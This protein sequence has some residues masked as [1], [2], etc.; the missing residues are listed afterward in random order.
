MELIGAA[1]QA[2][3]PSDFTLSGA[4]AKW[5]SLFICITITFQAILIFLQPVNWDEFRFLADIHQHRQG[6]LGPWL[7]TLHVHFFSWAVNVPGGEVSQ[8]IAG[9]CLI[10]LFECVTIAAIFVAARAFVAREE[11]LFAVLSYLAFSYV[12]RHG[13]SFRYD[14]I[15]TALLMSALALILW[16]RISLTRACI[17]AA[18]T[19]LAALVTVK[20]VFYLP[21]LA[22]AAIWRLAESQDS[23][24]DLVRI[25]IATGAGAATFAIV[26]IL[27][28]LTLAAPDAETAQRVVG[29][30]FLKTIAEAGL[31]PRLDAI[32]SSLVMDAL[33]WILIGLGLAKAIAALRSARRADPRLL[34]LLG[35]TL[36][37]ATLFFYRNAFPY[38]FA[39]ILAPATILA[40]F[41]LAGRDRLAVS[42]GAALVLLAGIHAATAPSPTLAVQ[43]AHVD[44]VHRMFPQPVPY[45]DR[46]SMIA[47]FPK[48]GFF[49]SSWGV[50]NYR[51]AGRPALREAVISTAPP[52]VIA[53]APALQ[54]AFAGDRSPLLPE[55]VQALRD[56]YIHHWGFLWVA[57]KHLQAVPEASV[58]Y[59]SIPGIYTIEGGGPVL[60]DHRTHRPG[61]TV[62]LSRGRHS[63]QSL[64]GEVDFTLRYGDNL[65]S[66]A[67]PPPSGPI[68]GDL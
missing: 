11:A 14:P 9:R 66:P 61:E 10:L 2:P 23:K 28:R 34:A 59:L 31:L 55:D 58:F 44:A 67:V 49:M 32:L 54:A 18:C 24:A 3:A 36:P 29:H 41:A 15:A 64:A 5:L 45:I 56:S 53:N 8:V 19:A 48:Q 20:A 68:F 4:A 46:A 65:F 27:H 40:G 57:G 51:D 62:A 60:I 6:T 50:E 33:I 63:V 25:G 12:V 1:A 38:Y 52:L 42:A 16:H 39:F 35:L 47:S 26:A 30:G 43:R 21:A 17:A 13:A 37:L 22:L 7:Q